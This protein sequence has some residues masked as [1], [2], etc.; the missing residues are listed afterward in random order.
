MG[1][2]ADK[3][4]YEQWDPFAA[5]PPL[6]AARLIVSTAASRKGHIL[7]SNDVKRAYFYAEARRRIYVELPPERQRP[8]ERK[9]ARLLKSLYGTRDAASNWAEQYSSVLT[10]SGFTRGRSNPCLFHHSSRGI[11]TLV[12]GDDFLSA[13]K[14]QDLAWLE[15]NIAAHMEIKTSKNR[16]RHHGKAA[17][18][19]W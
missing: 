11:T 7:M 13:G 2:Q 12:H 17:H 16:P 19:S 4:T 14:P 1:R 15:T 5:T 6:E 9:C 8:G 3:K 10:D 18:F